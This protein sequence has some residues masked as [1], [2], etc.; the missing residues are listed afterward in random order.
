MG[1]TAAPGEG[2]GRN[3]RGAPE[4]GKR[5]AP[6]RRAHSLLVTVTLC[7]IFPLRTMA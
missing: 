1:E 7:T 3:L 5:G 6:A 4:S 2:A